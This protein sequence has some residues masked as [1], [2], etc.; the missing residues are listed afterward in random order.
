MDAIDLPADVLITALTS[1]LAD[2]QCARVDSDSTHISAPHPQDGADRRALVAGQ[3]L[4]QLERRL[5]DGSNEFVP[6]NVLSGN[7]ERPQ[8]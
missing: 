6:V 1:R 7:T 5:I 8:H 3:L 2:L 4:G